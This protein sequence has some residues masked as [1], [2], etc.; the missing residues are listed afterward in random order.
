MYY[1]AGTP[2]DFA[3]F[4]IAFSEPW[5][6]VTSVKLTDHE[7]GPQPLNGN[8]YVPNLT[9][10]RRVEYKGDQSSGKFSIGKTPEGYYAISGVRRAD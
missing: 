2:D 9:D 5:G 7:D 3:E 8:E 10:L 6:S 1:L 4:M